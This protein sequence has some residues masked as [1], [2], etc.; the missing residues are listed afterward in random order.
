M[1]SFSTANDSILFHLSNVCRGLGELSSAEITNRLTC[2]LLAYLFFRF[3]R[4]FIRWRS[5]PLRHLPGP[6]G[7]FFMVGEFYTIFKEPFF[8]PHLKWWKES[9]YAPLISYPSLFGSWVVVPTDPDIIKHILTAPS[10][11]EPVRYYKRFDFFRD[12][13]GDGL[14]SLEGKT[15]SRHRRILQPC[16]QTSLVK[17]A[18][19]ATM[20]SKI[21]SLIESWQKSEGREIDVYAH[22]SAITL[23]ILGEVSFAHDFKA[24]DTIEKWAVESD[25]D[26]IGEIQDPMMQCLAKIFK[27]NLFSIIVGFLNMRWIQ[28]FNTKRRRTKQL[29]NDAAQDIIDA[30]AEN[31]SELNKVSLIHMMLSA[32]EKDDSSGGRNSLSLQELKDEVKMFIIAGHETSSTL[33]YWALYAL[34]K[35]PNVQEKVLQDI[36]KHAHPDKDQIDDLETVEKMEY[37]LAFVNECLRLFSPAGML[38][39]YN[40]KKEIW[41]GAVIPKKTRIILPLFLLHRHPTYW[42]QPDEFKKGG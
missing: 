31:K 25:T 19:T 18:L 17:A 11:Q 42:D 6:R 12:M 41:N 15:W 23:D 39:R 34:G 13:L 37:F 5:N 21:D 32:M 1:S 3:I 10:A 36:E 9:D 24:L 4:I 29:I 40:D 14:V 2:L 27:P 33:C 26:E 16:F 38:F 8:S 30:A 20:P 35:H 22:M 7:K 28:R